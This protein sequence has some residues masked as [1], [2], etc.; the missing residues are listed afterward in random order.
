[1]FVSKNKKQKNFIENL[2][3]FKKN[4]WWFYLFIPCVILFFIYFTKKSLLEADRITWL[5]Q[6]KSV[7]PLFHTRCLVKVINGARKKRNKTPTDKGH[8]CKSSI[9]W[10]SLFQSFMDYLFLFKHVTK[11]SKNS[12]SAF[13]YMCTHKP[14]HCGGLSFSTWEMKLLTPVQKSYWEGGVHQGKAQM[15]C[16]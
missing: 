3:V 4:L 10:M 6:I 13:V 1:M 9:N 15:H 14:T 2:V 11:K 5:I 16:G 8:M 7:S 12:L